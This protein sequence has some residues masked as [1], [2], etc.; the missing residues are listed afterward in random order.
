MLIALGYAGWTAGQ[1][2][3]EAS[4]KCLAELETDDSEANTCNSFLT[5][6]MAKNLISP[7]A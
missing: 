2:E 3:N 4:A 1:L 6:Q 7:C 5:S